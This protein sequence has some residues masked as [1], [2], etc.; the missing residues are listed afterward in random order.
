MKR[1]R[2]PTYLY[3]ATDGALCKIGITS[4]PPRRLPQLGP[5]VRYVKIWHRTSQVVCGLEAYVKAHF[6]DRQA[7]GEWF[8][9]PEPE[10]V[11]DVARAV[12]IED[13]DL[14]VFMG[15]EPSRRCDQ[16]FVPLSELPWLETVLRG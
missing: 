5:G 9:V 8:A 2:F 7:H 14:A 13:D 12:R 3:I 11:Q 15:R 16:P 1:N 4:H 6:H 10:F